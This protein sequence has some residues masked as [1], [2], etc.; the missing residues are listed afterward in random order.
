MTSPYI[1]TVSIL[2]SALSLV[3]LVA[4]DLY[5]APG[6]SAVASENAIN[7]YVGAKLFTSYKTAPSQKYPYFFPVNGPVS[8]ASVTTE[9][10]DPYPHHHSL[11]FGCDRV[12]GGNYWQESLD[13]GQIC[14]TSLR[15]VESEG[16]RVV[17]ENACE[18]RKPGEAPVARDSRRIQ[19]SAP[20]ETLRLIEFEIRITPVVDLRIDRTN[21]SLFAARMVPELSVLSG[22][23][24]VNAQGDTGEN[25]TFGKVSPWC[26]FYGERNGITEGLAIFQHPSNPLYPV[27]WFTRDYGFFSPTPL[28]WPQNDSHVELKAGETVTLRYLVAVH[29]GDTVSAG[30]GECFTRYATEMENASAPQ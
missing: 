8:D 5:G 14:S 24:L 7:V 29:S 21:H 19:I 1:R 28:Y 6:V 26:D 23:T 11:F 2:L 3:T 12:N 20:S 4:Q 18:W 13:K 22:G 30:I 9:S 10:S 25:G 27:M 16:A 17:L 15:I